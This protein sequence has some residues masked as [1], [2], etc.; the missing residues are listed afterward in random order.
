MAP[1]YDP[2]TQSATYSIDTKQIL[3][4]T[5]A[6]YGNPHY[7]CEMD[8]Y[9]NN[10][11][12]GEDRL[13]G[14]LTET[15]K[16]TFSKRWRQVTYLL[17]SIQ[18]SWPLAEVAQKQLFIF[19]NTIALD[20]ATKWISNIL[21]A[22]RMSTTIRLKTTDMTWEIGDI[23]EVTYIKQLWDGTDWY[24]HG[25]NAVKMMIIGLTEDYS[26][27]EYTLTLWY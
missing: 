13:S 4:L 26:K 9:F 18:T 14:T 6:R 23:V 22:E 1:I 11:P 20:A 27:N 16:A 5:Q 15:Q 25:L 19:A 8:Y 7:A 24:V 2:S 12:I 3:S 10:T 21:G 17:A